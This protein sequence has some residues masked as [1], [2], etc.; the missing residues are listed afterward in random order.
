ME[1]WVQ[2]PLLLMVHFDVISNK[3]AQMSVVGV[4]ATL[5]LVDEHTL[6]ADK[7]SVELWVQIPH[8]RKILNDAAKVVKL[9]AKGRLANKESQ[10]RKT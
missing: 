7:V 8:Q 9:K 4:K 6:V 2:A 5:A 10:R 1:T 3:E